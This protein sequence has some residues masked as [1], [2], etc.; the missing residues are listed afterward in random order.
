MF[1]RSDE[2]GA[3]FAMLP[4]EMVYDYDPVP[5]QPAHSEDTSPDAETRGG[6]L[7]EGG[8]PN[9]HPEPAHRHTDSND[10]MAV[11]AA[12]PSGSMSD[13]DGESSCNLLL[14]NQQAVWHTRRRHKETS[15]R[16]G[17]APRRAKS[18]VLRVRGGKGSYYGV[19]FV[20]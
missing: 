17:T 20:V 19:D 14:E 11:D 8:S 2:P 13:S 18:E 15:S 1:R 5:P 3:W 10:A 16:T 12:K 7:P 4:L 9:S 6:P